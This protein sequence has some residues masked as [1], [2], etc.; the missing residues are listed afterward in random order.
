MKDTLSQFRDARAGIISTGEIDTVRLYRQYKRFCVLGRFDT[1][2]RQR[3]KPSDRKLTPE[4]APISYD[5]FDSFFSTGQQVIMG[6][7]EWWV[8]VQTGIYVNDAKP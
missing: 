7:K 6:L 2:P 3:R 4:H 1:L 5:S 8:C